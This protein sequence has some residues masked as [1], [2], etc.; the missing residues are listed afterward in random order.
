MCMTCHAHAVQYRMLVRCPHR[1]RGTFHALDSPV[2]H[3]ARP[4]TEGQPCG[5]PG[6]P[7]LIG[8]ASA[9]VG[10]WSWSLAHPGH[11]QV[12]API[13]RRMGCAA[14]TQ[15]QQAQEQEQHRTWRLL[16]SPPQRLC[17]RQCRADILLQRPCVAAAPVGHRMTQACDG[18]VT[19]AAQD[20]YQLASLPV[21]PVLP[22][23]RSF[24]P[25]G[26]QTRHS[27]GS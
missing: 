15:I 20:G 8:A 25:G 10:S 2:S 1:P 24:Q 26:L 11:R 5:P 16:P 23:L 17:S 7:P 3:A 18:A 14:G 27:F 13:G 6:T 12:P 4:A 21:L 22:V 9:G 19:L